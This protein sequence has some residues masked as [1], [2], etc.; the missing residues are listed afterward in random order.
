[1]VA[2]LTNAADLISP[3]IFAASA[4]GAKAVTFVMDTAID[5]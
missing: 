1:L 3:N 2:G 4:S 5:E